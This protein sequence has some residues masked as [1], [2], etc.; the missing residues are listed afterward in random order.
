MKFTSL[1]V[2]KN[3]SLVS[4]VVDSDEHNGFAFSVRDLLEVLEP[5]EPIFPL[6]LGFP[7]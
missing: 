4:C 1:I 5:E 2:E 6:F 3:D 7:Q